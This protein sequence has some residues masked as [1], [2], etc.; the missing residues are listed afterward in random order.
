MWMK[1][2]RKENPSNQYMT[3]AVAD[4]ITDE[5]KII[6][7]IQPL[8][9][10]S[11]DFDLVVDEDTDKAYIYFDKVHDFKNLDMLHKDIVCGELTD[12]YTDVTGNYANYHDNT[13]YYL[14]IEAPAFC[15]RGEKM[16]LFMSRTTGYIPNPTE[17]CVA[18]NY[19]G[20]WERLGRTHEDSENLSFRSQYSAI[21]KHP[22]KKD[23]YIALADRWLMDLPEDLPQNMF[24]IENSKL[25]PDIETLSDPRHDEA[26][27]INC[28]ALRDLSISRYVWLPI[29]FDGDKPKVYWLDEWRWEDYD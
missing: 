8:G 12:D 1:I 21:F 27:R 16:Y 29:I 3:I 6:K 26:K 17:V 4:K 24:E 2:M 5:F 7:T 14:G 10:S 15:K 25:D 19:F 28:A 9:F 18:D 13:P 22:E 11:G 23:L 20:P